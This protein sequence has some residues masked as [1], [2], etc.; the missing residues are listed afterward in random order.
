MG[1]IVFMSIKKAFVR[2]L[3]IRASISRL[4]RKF[5]IKFFFVYNAL[6]KSAIKRSI[7]SFDKLT[8]LTCFSDYRI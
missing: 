2:N 1:F 3:I 7:L 8:G 6:Y 5:D 4:L